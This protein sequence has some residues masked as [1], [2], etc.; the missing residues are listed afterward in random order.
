MKYFTPDL[1]LRFAATDDAIADAASEEWD[2]V[3]AKYV[4]HLEAIEPELPRSFRRLLR[5]VC[6][7]DARVLT[8]TVDEKPY[9]SILLRPLKPRKPEDRFLEIRYHLL[10]KPQ[11]ARHAALAEEGSPYQRW[12]YD[13]VDVLKEDPFAVFTHSI[14]LTGGVELRIRFSDVSVRR[15]A[16]AWPTTPAPYPPGEDDVPEGIELVPA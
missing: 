9:L 15:L 3:H 10:G 5:N 4:E 12:L 7:H 8:I 16:W 13:E 2:R 11:F 6:L 14:L 1:L